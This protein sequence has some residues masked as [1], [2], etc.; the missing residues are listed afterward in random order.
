MNDDEEGSPP[1]DPEEEAPPLDDRPQDLEVRIPKLLKRGLL[2]AVM[3]LAVGLLFYALAPPANPGA[4]Y[5]LNRLP[6]L[7]AAAD[8]RG[9]IGLGLL[10][11][12]LTPLGRVAMSLGHFAKQ[13]D[14]LYVLLT[15]IVFVNISIAVALGAF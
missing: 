3:L 14:R 2:A 1:L 9:V 11:L 12:L 4:P 15:A 7:L 8:P 13:R 10:A 5:T 6:E